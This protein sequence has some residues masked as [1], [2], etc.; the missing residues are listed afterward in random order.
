[1]KDEKPALHDSLHDWLQK[2]WTGVSAIATH[3]QRNYGWL[4]VDCKLLFDARQSR[5]MHRR[6]F[7]GRLAEP[8]FQDLW[9]VDRTNDSCEC[10]S[11]HGEL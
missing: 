6:A 8:I 3:L 7:G 1:M 10:V 5:L 2:G 11:A 9:G 4:I